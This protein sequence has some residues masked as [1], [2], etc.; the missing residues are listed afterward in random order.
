YHTSRLTEQQWVE[1]LRHRHTERIYSKLGV[2]LYVHN[3]SE[4]PLCLCIGPDALAGLIWRIAVDMSV[5]KAIMPSLRL[6]HR[7]RKDMQI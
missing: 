5:T 6:C 1:E 4:N 2:H 3:I 7:C